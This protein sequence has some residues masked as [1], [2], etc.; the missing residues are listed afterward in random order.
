[1]L[2]RHAAIFYAAMLSL[3][4]FRHA[5]TPP[6]LLLML[7]RRHAAYFFFCHDF[8]AAA[9]FSLTPYCCMLICRADYFHRLLVMRRHD[10]MPHAFTMARRC[11]R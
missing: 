3:L 9:S 10:A 1:M 7:S 6:P 8:A 4:V 11:C 5:A 2:L